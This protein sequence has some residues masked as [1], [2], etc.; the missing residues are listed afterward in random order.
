MNDWFTV[1]QTRGDL[2]QC[3]S[4]SVCGTPTLVTFPGTESTFRATI[5]SASAPDVTGVVAWGISIEAV[6]G[7][8][9]IF[10]RPE[11]SSRHVDV[12]FGGSGDF[13]V[14][15]ILF[16]DEV[17]QYCVVL[18]VRDFRNGQ[19][20]LSGPLCKVT[21]PSTQTVLDYPLYM[22]AQPPSPA[23]TPRWCETHRNDPICANVVADAGMAEVDSPQPPTSDAATGAPPGLDASPPTS[24]AS[25]SDPGLGLQPVTSSSGCHCR[26]ALGGS[27][28]PS[29]CGVLAFALLALGR[30]PRLMAR[31]PSLRERRHVGDEPL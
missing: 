7:M 24:D 26:A 22:C 13:G 5:V 31:R 17:A 15:R 25:M 27:S 29:S 23:L 14:G 20:V 19:E 12:T 30:I 18:R 21:G 1:G 8:G 9:S 10:E 11:L 16:G 2:V 3:T 6:D 4:N 28:S